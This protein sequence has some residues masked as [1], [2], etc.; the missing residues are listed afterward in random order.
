MARSG[1]QDP[2]RVVAG[3]DVV[4][5]LGAPRCALRDA[6]RYINVGQGRRVR[7]LRQ[8]GMRKLPGCEPDGSQVGA[9][10]VVGAARSRGA[11]SV[12]VVGEGADVADRESTRGGRDDRV[13]RDV[14]GLTVSEPAQPC[15]G[16]GCGGVPTVTS[17]ICTA[18]AEP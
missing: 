3:E 12:S 9:Q 5:G 16:P 10:P 15:C 14:R 7:L 1:Q 18:A 8:P 2:D 6:P 13:R 17:P 4:G 11:V